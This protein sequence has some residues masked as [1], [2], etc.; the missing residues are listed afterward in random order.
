MTRPGL[1]P[2]RLDPDRAGTMV[3][4]E[5]GELFCVCS[6]TGKQRAM[7]FEG[8]ER[9]REKLKHRC[10]AAAYGFDCAGRAACHRMGGCKA[11]AYGRVVRIPLECGGPPDLHADALGEPLLAARLQPPERAGAHQ[12]PH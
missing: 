6:E 12:F 10:L 9:D 5:R 1:S 7:A 2:V 8:F 11:G 3:H 4:S